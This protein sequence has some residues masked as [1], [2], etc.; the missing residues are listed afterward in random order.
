MQMVVLTYPK[1]DEQNSLC[2]RTVGNTVRL[3][4]TKILFVD[5]TLS[6]F[7]YVERGVKKV[8]KKQQS[9]VCASLLRFFFIIFFFSHH[10]QSFHTSLILFV[11]PTFRVV[12]TTLL[13]WSFLFFHCLCDG[14]KRQINRSQQSKRNQRT[15]RRLTTH[16]FLLKQIL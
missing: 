9:K 2:H 15:N 11:H 8:Y 7:I 16:Y 5:P 4:M 1:S 6:L 12:T 3:T 14:N 13:S 10:N